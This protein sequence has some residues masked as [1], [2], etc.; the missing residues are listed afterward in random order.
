M[1]QPA[2]SIM[3]VRFNSTVNNQKC[4][5]V[6]HYSIA[7]QWSSATLLAEY[8]DFIQQIEASA[9]FDIVTPY[10]D[11]CS[12]DLTLDSIDL[13]FIW[14]I[15][16]VKYNFPL[17]SPGA[18]AIACTAQNVSGVIEKYTTLAGRQYRGNV[19]MPGVPSTG[20]TAGNLAAGYGSDLQALAVV[21]DNQVAEDSGPG[22]SNPCIF[23]RSP[24]ANPKYTN[25][26][27][28]VAMPHIRT[29]RRRTVGVGV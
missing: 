9:T 15:R 1:G 4:V 2:G 10:L 19:H 23:H 28:C 3:E 12:S 22:I 16:Y 26:T 13:Q 18:N 27:T 6:L 20:Y 29:M 25:I 7:V 17:M 24:N 11:C 8:Q 14:P 5:T 21:L